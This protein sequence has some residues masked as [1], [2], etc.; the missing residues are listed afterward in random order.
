MEN[1]SLKITKSLM[2]SSFAFLP[3]HILYHKIGLLNKVTRK[4]LPGSGLLDQMI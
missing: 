4:M 1:S 3:G 2:L